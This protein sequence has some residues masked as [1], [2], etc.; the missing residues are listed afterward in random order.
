MKD[1]MPQNSKQI[2]AVALY[3]VF[4]VLAAFGKALLL[5]LL[6]LAH[7]CE[8][9]FISRPLANDKGIPQV[10]ALIHTL[11]YGFTWWKPIKEAE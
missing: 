2:T 6:F 1:F 5:I 9:A 3:V 8:Y 11:I 7:C 4:G 10:S